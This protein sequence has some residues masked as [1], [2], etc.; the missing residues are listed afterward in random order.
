MKYESNRENKKIEKLHTQDFS[1]P[2]KNKKFE[3]V[4][5]KYLD[6][7]NTNSS[8][9]PS[10]LLKN[11]EDKKSMDKLIKLDTVK[12]NEDTKKNKVHKY[13]LKEDCISN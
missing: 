13:F 12:N 3:G 7:K 9:K 11:P 4:K 5:S 10:L 1:K 6:W 2:K 8:S